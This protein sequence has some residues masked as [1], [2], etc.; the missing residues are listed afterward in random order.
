[1]R[2]PKM[3]TMQ[4]VPDMSART[5]AYWDKYLAA[6]DTAET[7]RQASRSAPDA[8]VARAMR[9]NR[10]TTVDGMQAGLRE[11]EHMPATATISKDEAGDVRTAPLCARAAAAGCAAAACDDTTGI[12][13]TTDATGATGAN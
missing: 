13:G 3:C 6:Q 2:L 1:M 8:A 7:A 11:M 10:S 4:H 12:V 5:L 9:G